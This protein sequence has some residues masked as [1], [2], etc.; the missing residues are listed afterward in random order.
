MSRLS[1]FR[2]I[3]STA[4]MALPPNHNADNIDFRFIMI[5]DNYA[6][7]AKFFNN[8]FDIGVRDAL[9]ANRKDAYLICSLHLDPDGLLEE[10]A[11][12][13]RDVHHTALTARD[14]LE[15]TQNGGIQRFEWSFPSIG[16]ED[17]P[18]RRG[19]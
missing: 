17:G 14:T 11:S 16:L 1:I 2:F 5:S 7:I 13:A 9:G 4:T 19:G 12:F 15:R 18:L 8:A 6:E 3:S 10:S